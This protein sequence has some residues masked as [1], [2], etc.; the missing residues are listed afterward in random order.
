MHVPILGPW[1]ALL[2]VSGTRGGM[3]IGMAGQ[4]ER[5]EFKGHQ[6]LWLCARD[7]IGVEQRAAPADPLDLG[8]VWALILPQLRVLSYECQRHGLVRDLRRF[9]AVTEPGDHDVSTLA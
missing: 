2:Q 5:R 8:G 7:G 1:D 4:D 3:K 9:H 6:F